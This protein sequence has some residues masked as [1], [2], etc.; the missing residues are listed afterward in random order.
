MD[1][2][3]PDK[4]CSWIQCPDQNIS[5]VLLWTLYPWIQLN[6]FPF[7]VFTI[8]KTQKTNRN[9]V[10][11]WSVVFQYFSTSIDMNWDGH[12]AYH[13]LFMEI[14]LVFWLV[15]STN[16]FTSNR[17]KHRINTIRISHKIGF[18]RWIFKI[19]IVNGSMPL[20]KSVQV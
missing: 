6:S 2:I 1:S 8:K 13:F 12:G 10:R 9:S 20:M 14:H 3:N 16:V 11:I 7:L 5:N 4:K 17:V 18:C 15:N 19:L